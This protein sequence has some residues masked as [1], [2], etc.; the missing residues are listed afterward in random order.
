MLSMNTDK[1][2]C[3]VGAHISTRDY[4]SVTEYDQFIG[5][6]N[7]LIFASLMRRTGMGW[8]SARLL[9]HC[10]REMHINSRRAGGRTDERT[11]LTP[12][13][14]PPDT[15]SM[16]EHVSTRVE[17]CLGAVTILQH[18]FS[19]YTQ[20]M[21]TFPRPGCLGY[22]Y[23]CMWCSSSILVMWCDVCLEAP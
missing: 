17:W 21:F 14:P 6:N 3:R 18:L 23:L 16:Y 11:A 9:C 8:L 12:V 10:F 20:V 5:D 22:N 15:R 7:I 1:S 13:L 2:R 19:T 4:C